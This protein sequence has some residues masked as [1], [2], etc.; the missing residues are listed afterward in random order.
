MS[1]NTSMAGSMEESNFLKRTRTV[2]WARL[3]LSVLTT[4]VAVAV[5]A[6]EAVPLQH[7]QNTAQWAS[8]GLVLW[9]LNLDVRPNIAALACGCVVGV[10]SAAY[11]IVA[12]L[13]S[14][15]PRI[16]LLNS[17]SSASS[18]AGFLTALVAVTFSIYRPSASYPSGFT[19]GET[20]Q[21][22]T[23][24]WKASNG[25]QSAPVDF[26]R[27]CHATQAG[28]AL[29]CTLLALQILMGFAAIAGT[30]AQR[31]VARRR[32][33]NTQLEKLEIATKQLYHA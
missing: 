2:H 20:L 5:V 1:S 27:D 23:C 33:E 4:A 14:P 29:V 15:H 26:S 12:L 18:F 28:F 22:W 7:H 11:T 16:K 24:K 31:D 32:E 3:C 10:L 8:I 19:Q 30:L 21:S 25:A 17:Y 6:C 13:P 9:P